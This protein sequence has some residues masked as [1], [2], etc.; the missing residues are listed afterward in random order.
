V[1]VPARTPKPIIAK[2]ASEMQRILAMPDIAEKLVNSGMEPYYS[3]PEK[4]MAMMKADYAETAKI[5]KE[6]K[7]RIEE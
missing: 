2:L 7:I 3:G 5:I 1:L 4:M 6:A